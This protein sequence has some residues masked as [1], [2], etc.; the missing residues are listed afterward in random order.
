MFGRAEVY[1]TSRS[2]QGIEA[3]VA[4]AQLGER[5]AEIPVPMNG[6]GLITFPRFVLSGA[7]RR[8]FSG[9]AGAR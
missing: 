7:W 8:N 1:P 2:S 6:Q 4:H 9:A 5:T 3:A